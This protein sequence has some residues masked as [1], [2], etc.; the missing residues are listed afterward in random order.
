[1]FHNVI[2]ICVLMIATFLSP[3][4][5]YLPNT[6][7]YIEQ[8]PHTAIDV[9]PQSQVKLL[10]WLALLVLPVPHQGIT[11]VWAPSVM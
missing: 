10:K 4:K 11:I 6:S 2:S 1:M 3:A 7:L 8:I 5:I 9:A